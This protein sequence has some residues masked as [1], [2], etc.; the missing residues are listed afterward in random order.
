[1]GEG[2]AE[3]VSEF[4]SQINPMRSV[5]TVHHNDNFITILVSLVTPYH[6]SY[7]PSTCAQLL[8]DIDPTLTDFFSIR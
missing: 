8:H 5:M 7:L 3:I 6:L 4:Q 2:T 1:M